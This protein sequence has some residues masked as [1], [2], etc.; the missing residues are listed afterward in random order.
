MHSLEAPGFDAP[1]RYRVEHTDYCFWLYHPKQRIDIFSS[2]VFLKKIRFS[3]VFTPEIFMS[4]SVFE[5]GVWYDII[6]GT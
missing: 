5:T 6:F 4:V 1:H 2:L 3:E